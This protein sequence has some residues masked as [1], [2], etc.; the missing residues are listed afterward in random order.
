MDCQC[1]CPETFISCGNIV[2]VKLQPR[3]TKRALETKENFNSGT[4]ADSRFMPKMVANPYKECRLAYMPFEVG[5]ARQD[6][7]FRRSQ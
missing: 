1:G 4:Q 3:N 2:A 5:K 6:T 7:G